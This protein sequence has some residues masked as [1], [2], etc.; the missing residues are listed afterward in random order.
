LRA[1]VEWNLSFQLLELVLLGHLLRRLWQGLADELFFLRRLVPSFSL[2]RSLGGSLGRLLR[3]LVYVA[4]V[5]RAFGA[6]GGQTGPNAPLH[7]RKDVL[8]GLH[9]AYLQLDLLVLR[10]L[11]KGLEVNLFGRLLLDEGVQHL[12]VLL[13][14]V[15][16]MHWIVKRRDRSD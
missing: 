6:A 16:G 1:V 12:R 4:S 7:R 14:G 5:E 11:L 3:C 10:S 15:D 2:R 9:S 13:R 8:L